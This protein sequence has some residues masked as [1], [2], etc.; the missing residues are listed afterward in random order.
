MHADCSSILICWHMRSLYLYDLAVLLGCL[1]AMDVSS[2]G[3]GAVGLTGVIRCNKSLPS[4]RRKI[5]HFRNSS[6][7]SGE[8]PYA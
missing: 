4:N 6:V 8:R 1:E 7:M 5:P 2:L 3:C